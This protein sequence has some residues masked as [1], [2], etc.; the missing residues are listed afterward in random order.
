MT[1]GRLTRQ[2][3]YMTKMN[4]MTKMTGQIGRMTIMIQMDKT[5]T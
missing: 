1:N 2:T 5:D 3:R 4:G